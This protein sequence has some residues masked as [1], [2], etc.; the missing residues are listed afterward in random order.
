M[1]TMKSLLVVLH[2]VVLIL[3]Y[4]YYSSLAA[5]DETNET[6]DDDES[7]NKI[8][9]YDIL[10]YGANSAGVAAAVTGSK[11][12]KYSVLIMENLHMIGGMAAAGGV[13]LMNQ[14]GCGLSGLAYQWN[15]NVGKYYN[16]STGMPFPPFPRMKE[17][18]LAFWDLLRYPNST[19]DVTLGCHVI[20][21]HKKQQ[22]GGEYISQVDFLCDDDDNNN[23]KK[24]KRR[25]K[26]KIIK[27]IRSRYVIDSSYDGDIMV[28]AGVDYTS[29]R[30]SQSV[31]NESLAGVQIKEWSTLE[32]FKGQNLSSSI[33]PYDD[34]G[35]LLKY[36]NPKPMSD[37]QG[38]GDDKLMSYEY[39]VCLT[40]TPKNI[41]PFNKEPKGYNPKD[42]ELLLR[43]TK[44]AMKHG[45]PNGP[46]LSWFGDVQCY[47]PIVEK[48][49]GNKGM[50][51]CTFS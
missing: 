33:D 40:T 2:T 29:G 25:N 23:K 32:S 1:F 36:I 6:V 41:L 46:P 24:K 13:S 28:M 21:V 44:A 11:R 43:Q 10:V 30:E 18:E 31:Y 51:V 34:N 3:Y 17:S 47:D 8:L 9:Y 14:G 49:T 4:Y 22:Q 16:L 39:F 26:K 19:I 5:A 35:N 37:Q 50:F 27:K 48:I 42:F 20:N 45:F 15:I 12:G 38:S 7:T